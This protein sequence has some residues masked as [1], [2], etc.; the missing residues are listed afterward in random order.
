[1]KRLII[2]F[3]VLSFLWMIASCN[4]QSKRAVD[5][6][7]KQVEGKLYDENGHFKDDV[8]NQLLQLYLK[9]VDSMPSDT[10]TPEFLFKAADVSV[11]MRNSS[12]TLVL[13]NKFNR[14]YPNSKH[15]PMTLFLKAFVYENQ[16]VDTAQARLAYEEFIFKYPNH[17]FAEDARIAIKNMG[18]TPEQLIR[19]FEEQNDSVE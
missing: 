12:R 19:E 18:K 7:I 15:A 10:L 11:N 3:S 8:A 1:M 5:D 13:L 9:R 6:E 17:E 16:L 4:Q 2:G 14:D